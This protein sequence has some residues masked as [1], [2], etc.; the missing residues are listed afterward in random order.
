M[1]KS[2]SPQIELVDGHAP[3]RSEGGAILLVGLLFA[4]VSIGF[5]WVL[6]HLGDVLVRQEH[7]NGAADAVALS[8]AIQHARL[9]NMIVLFNLIMSAILTV[10]VV[11]RVLEVA[12]VIAALPTFGASLAALP[13]LEA[14]YR[15]TTPG[16]VTALQSLGMAAGTMILTVPGVAQGTATYIAKSYAPVAQQAIATSA[17]QE[18]YGAVFG[19]PLEQDLTGQ[20]ECK[21]T[22]S[23]ATDLIKYP[24]D[25]IGMGFIAKFAGKP[26]RKILGVGSPFFCGLGLNIQPEIPGS[27]ELLESVGEDCR[28][29]LKESGVDPSSPQGQQQFKLC[30]AKVEGPINV[31]EGPL[32]DIANQAVDGLVGLTPPTTFKTAKQWHNG[33]AEWGILAVVTLEDES[34]K[35]NRLVSLSG[36]GKRSVGS[37]PAVSNKALAQ[38]EFFY[39]CNSHWEDGDCGG[40]TE[41]MWNFRWRARLVPVF[42]QSPT[43][44]ELFEQ[45]RPALSRELDVAGGSPELAGALKGMDRRVVH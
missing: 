35:D 10:R 11:L 23:F 26:I 40:P 17:G 16:V 44:S 43:L 29:Q 12:A 34:L 8:V 18:P 4:V 38:A 20:T 41:P 21:K 24:L 6:F 5:I 33:V 30:M 39:D 15:S 45:L 27:D 3:D 32:S 9:L 31:A 1:S 36:F 19:L 37:L 14:A 7:G 42:E 2:R 13:V 28:K 25:K 22:A